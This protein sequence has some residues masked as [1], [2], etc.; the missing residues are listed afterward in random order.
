MILNLLAINLALADSPRKD[1]LLSGGG[2]NPPRAPEGVDQS[3]TPVG[4]NAAVS[5]AFWLECA[6]AAGFFEF[7]SRLPSALL[8]GSGAVLTQGAD[9]FAT[10]GGRLSG[11]FRMA[12]RGTMVLELPVT[13]ELDA[14]KMLADFEQQSSIHDMGDNLW[15]MEVPTGRFWAELDGD[16]LRTSTRKGLTPTT[17]ADLNSTYAQTLPRTG[18]CAVVIEDM[19]S[20]ALPMLN[21]RPINTGVYLPFDDSP[22]LLQGAGWMAALPPTSVQRALPK[23]YSARQPDG[24][25]VVSAPVAELLNVE[26]I[27]GIFQLEDKEVKRLQRQLK[28]SDGAVVAA[29]TLNG[30]MSEPDVVMAIPMRTL[31]DWELCPSLIWTGL[32]HSLWRSGIKAEKVGKH[33]LSI[34]FS[35]QRSIFLGVLDGMLLVST[36]SAG[37]NEVMAEEGELW[38]VEK[39]ALGD[40]PIAG[41]INVPQMLSMMVGGIS[42]INIGMKGAADGSE[43]PVGEIAIDARTAA[44]TPA[45]SALLQMLG[46]RAQNQ[47]AETPPEWLDMMQIAAKQHDHFAEHGAYLEVSPGR[48]NAERA[49]NDA[50]TL[51]AL[52]WFADRES[53]ELDN[54]WV[55]VTDQGFVVG[56]AIEIPALYN[57]EMIETQ[58][59]VRIILKNEDGQLS[60]RIEITEGGMEAPAP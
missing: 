52:G 20:T 1:A 2:M 19:P 45:L 47:H 33:Q 51:T 36:T 50:P 34:A 58:Q 16:V 6:P 55:E 28:R 57:P 26:A 14:R 22:L 23:L 7:S 12:G 40:W 44:G 59:T 9:N 41:T 56:A 35:E 24:L 49:V 38:P 10:K 8:Q 31:F 21:G 18:G 17:A 5:P 39:L 27:K 43:N 48:D 54:Y 30:V 53:E 13:A 11:R 3:E 4:T 15:V 60:E 29:R 37:L 46:G 32:K 25:F 42:T